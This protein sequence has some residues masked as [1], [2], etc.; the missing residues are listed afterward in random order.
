MEQSRVNKIMI[1]ILVVIVTAVFAIMIRGYLMTL[2]LAGLFASLNQ[3]IYHGLLKKTKDRK[4]LSSA[5]TL[6]IFLIIV[7][8]L[9]SGNTL[10]SR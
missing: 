1:L 7:I 8:A 5:L 2:F 4:S 3:P 10:P 6:L 9:G